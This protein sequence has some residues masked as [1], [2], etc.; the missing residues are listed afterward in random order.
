[1][2][3]LTYGLFVAGLV[4]Y[5][6]ALVLWDESA[7]DIGNAVMLV[8]AVILLLRIRHVLEGRTPAG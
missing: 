3:V 8:T 2:N 6:F 7:S 5:G 1:M 4:A